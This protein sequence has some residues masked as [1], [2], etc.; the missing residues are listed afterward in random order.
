MVAVIRRCLDAILR[1]IPL[2]R[3]R[4][5][6]VDGLRLPDEVAAAPSRP[7]VVRIKRMAIFVAAALVMKDR[8]R[9]VGVPAVSVRLVD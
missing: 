5:V 9:L 3:R 4:I 1:N 7:D 6:S 8:V 2:P